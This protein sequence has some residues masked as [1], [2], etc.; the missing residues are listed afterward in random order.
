MNPSAK[1][2]PWRLAAD[3][4]QLIIR[5]VAIPIAF[6]QLLSGELFRFALGSL[7]GVEVF[8]RLAW[9]PIRP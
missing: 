7:G 3:V 4:C 6:S 1:V 8:V 5:R 2:R 9:V